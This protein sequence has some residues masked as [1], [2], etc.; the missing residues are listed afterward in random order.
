[1]GMDVLLILA[2]TTLNDLTAPGIMGLLV[3]QLGTVG[4]AAIK[5]I[6][7]NGKRENKCWAG[8]HSELIRGTAS[9]AKDAR[10][11]LEVMDDDHSLAVYNERGIKKAILEM[12]TEIVTEIR[13]L[14]VAI[15]GRSSGGQ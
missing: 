8:D 6:R 1:M 5:S 15:E 4:T 11:I 3:L 12:K 7:R 9:D 14:R 10:E 2:E 13:N